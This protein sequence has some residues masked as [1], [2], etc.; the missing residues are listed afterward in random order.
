MNTTLANFITRGGIHFAITNCCC[1]AKFSNFL[2]N[3]IASIG[4]PGSTSD[5][6][7]RSI[8][9]LLP[10]SFLWFRPATGTLHRLYWRLRFEEL[11]Q[12]APQ[13]GH[14]RVDVL[15]DYL[16]RSLL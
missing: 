13:F 16:I 12:H 11:Q 3:K 8:K 6:V 14:Q 1:V 9:F 5:Q 7:V 10:S 15:T 2:G 4:A